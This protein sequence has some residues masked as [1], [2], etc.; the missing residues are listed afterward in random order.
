MFVE[1]TGRPTVEPLL[2][3]SIISPLW[4]NAGSGAWS[5][6]CTWFPQASQ[7]P[8]EE[9]EAQ[10]LQPKNNGFPLSLI[11]PFSPLCQ[12][13]GSRSKPDVPFLSG[14]ICSGSAEDGTANETGMV[15]DLAELRFWWGDRRQAG[16]ATRG[17]EEERGRPPE[18]RPAGGAWASAQPPQRGRPGSEQKPVRARQGFLPVRTQKNAPVGGAE[19]T[20][21]ARERPSARA[22]CWQ[23]RRAG[24]VRSCKPQPTLGQ[25]EG[26]G[27]GF[28]WWGDGPTRAF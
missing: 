15:P 11:S 22:R 6:E 24:H 16:A 4:T 20:S 8:Q 25:A 23:E 10:V 9:Q 26:G 28:K 2:R 21:G 12:V 18:R 13:P 19:L 27:Q 17:T 7:R 5:L 3:P 1:S 14:G